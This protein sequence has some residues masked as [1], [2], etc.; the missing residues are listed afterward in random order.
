[1]ELHP[2][3]LRFGRRLLK[4][5]WSY[6]KLHATRV[7]HALPFRKLIDFLREAIWASDGTDVK[8]YFSLMLG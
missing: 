6:Y 4:R 5:D 2:D 3:G 8:L 1:A 7:A